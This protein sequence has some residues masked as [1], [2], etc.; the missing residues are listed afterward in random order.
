MKITKLSLIKNDT[1]LDGYFNP[2]GEAIKIAKD[3]LLNSKEVLLIKA[4]GDDTYA[5]LMRTNNESGEQF[6]ETYIE[7]KYENDSLSYREEKKALE[8]LFN[9]ITA[10]LDEKQKVSLRSLSGVVMNNQEIVNQNIKIADEEVFQ[11]M[12]EIYSGLSDVAFVFTNDERKVID[13]GSFFDETMIH[14]ENTTITLGDVKSILTKAKDTLL[15]QKKNE[16][17]NNKD[18]ILKISEV[19]NSLESD[20]KLDETLQTDL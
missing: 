17:I 8:T 3:M 4:E 6:T 13:L 15:K 9:S 2:K 12:Q 7:D 11:N 5:N 16:E 10:D 20:E 14:E 19:N 18:F 1:N